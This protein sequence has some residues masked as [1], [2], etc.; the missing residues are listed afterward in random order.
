MKKYTETEKKKITEQVCALMSAGMP[1]GKACSKVGVPKSTFLGWTQTGGSAAD[2]YALAREELIDHW[3]EDVLNIAD[4]D[5]VQVVDQNGVAR[6]DA[7]AVQHARLRIDSR[8]W[9]LSK[10]KPKEYGDKVTQEHTGKDGGPI[11][12]AGIDLKNLEDGELDN[13]MKLLEKATKGED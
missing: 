4:A 13:M 10:L 6:Y 11:T 1:C 8:K 3:A 12:M 2:Q 9:L 5:P 7:A